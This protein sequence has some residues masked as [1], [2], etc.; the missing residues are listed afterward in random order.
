MFGQRQVRKKQFRAK[1][2]PEC[3]LNNVWSKTSSKKNNLEQKPYLKAM[4][5]SN[6]FSK[7][8]NGIFVNEKQTRQIVTGRMTNEA[9]FA[10][11]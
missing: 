6:S 3:S 10:Q 7:N 2:V 5:R 8:G 9:N 4:I 1:A 11:H